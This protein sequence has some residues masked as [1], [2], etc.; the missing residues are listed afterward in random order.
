MGGRGEPS[1]PAASLP[2]PPRRPRGSSSDV[3]VFDELAASRPRVAGEPPAP[4]G[5]SGVCYAEF[6]EGLVG[7]VEINFSAGRG[8]RPSDSNRRASRPPRRRSSARPGERAGS[9]S[10][11]A[12]SGGTRAR[13]EDTTR[14]QGNR[15]RAGPGQL[16]EAPSRSAALRRDR[17]G[18]LRER[19]AEPLDK[20]VDAL[21][22]P[23][24]LRA[25]VLDLLR[26]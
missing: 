15:R 22:V 16:R 6:G 13:T 20:R 23:G 3:P 21:P 4:Y 25:G 14:G 9:G 11:S 26:E 1:G 7:K 10:D 12:R 19:G 17:L 18:D 2:R 8:R 5:A 24:L